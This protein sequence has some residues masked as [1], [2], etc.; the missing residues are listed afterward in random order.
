M[1][2]TS[3]KCI[4]SKICRHIGNGS[5]ANDLKLVCQIM[6]LQS[7]VGNLLM[8]CV[9]WSGVAQTGTRTKMSQWQQFL[10]VIKCS[11][12]ITYKNIEKR[13]YLS[14]RIEI[15]CLITILLSIPLNELPHSKLW[16]K[17][18]NSMYQLFQK[19]TYYIHK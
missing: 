12:F 19:Y 3:S 1:Q 6:W 4:E 18:R 14:K 7:K 8:G 5:R 10:Y 11:H 13:A 15:H 17:T 9:N 2:K 16:T